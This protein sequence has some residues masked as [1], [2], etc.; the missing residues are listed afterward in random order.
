MRGSVEAVLIALF[1]AGGAGGGVAAQVRASE[2]GSVSQTIDGAVL[3]I[4]YSRPRARGR[5]P[6]FGKVVTWGEVWTPGANW[7]TTLEVSREV[8]LDGHPIPKGKYSV[9]FVVQPRQWTVVL[10][11]AVQRYHTEPPDSSGGQIRWAVR[12]VA[13]PATEVLTWAF[14]DIRPGGGGLQ[15][16]WG[17]TR[18]AIDVDV[19][20]RHPLTIA[21]SEIEPFLGRYRISMSLTGPDSVYQGGEVVE[22]IYE[23]GSLR[24][25]YQPKPTWYPSLQ[26]SIMVRIND[27]WFI[28]TI[29][30]N[31]QI[32][33]MVADMVFEF[34]VVDGKATSFEIRDD[35]DELLGRGKRIAGSP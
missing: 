31:G 28:P 12:P 23:G 33:E 16:R 26:E 9:W 18:I 8:R 6:L 32:L 7:A 25:R 21:R 17:T 24:A 35:H 30:R 4:N 10:D 27:D 1:V 20:P 14:P 22:L 15:M 13:A 11:T 3:T 29:V 34:T 2:R 19:P 5:S